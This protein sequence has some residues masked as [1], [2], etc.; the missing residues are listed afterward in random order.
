MARDNRRRLDNSAVKVR[1]LGYSE[2]RI[3]YIVQDM[4]SRRIMYSRTFYCDENAFLRRDQLIGN[5]GE[6]LQ[7]EPPRIELEQEQDT[8]EIRD[9]NDAYVYADVNNQQNDQP[10]QKNDSENPKLAINGVPYCMER[11]P[12]VQQRMDDILDQGRQMDQL[13]AESEQARRQE[14]EQL[15]LEPV[16]P[17]IEEQVDSMQDQLQQDIT[18]L[19][20][21]ESTKHM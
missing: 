10:S 8:D 18:Q 16:E 2:D 11:D 12:A 1:F 21:A 6:Q 9:Y 7:L 13:L 14:V 15:L 4:S 3:G 20:A 19:E 17:N 5:T